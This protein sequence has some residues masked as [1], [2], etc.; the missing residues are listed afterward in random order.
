LSELSLF[1]NSANSVRGASGHEVAVRTLCLQCRSPPCGGDAL[2]AIF[3][4]PRDNAGLASLPF[5][6]AGREIESAAV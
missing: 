1:Y 6:A 3:P 4:S 2:F 5:P